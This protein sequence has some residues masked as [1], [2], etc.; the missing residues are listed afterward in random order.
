MF[1]IL[2]PAELH[3]NATLDFWPLCIDVLAPTNN[4]EMENIQGYAGGGGAAQRQF[5]QD[6]KAVFAKMMRD[7]NQHLLVGLCQLEFLKLVGS[8]LTGEARQVLTT[9]LEHCDFEDLRSPILVDAVDIER[10]RQLWREHRRDTSAWSLNRGT[11]GPARPVEPVEHEPSGFSR[12]FDALEARLKISTNENLAQVQS[13][14]IKLGETPDRMF[15]RFYQLVKPLED[16]RPQMMTTE[17]LKTM[18]VFHLHS[19]LNKEDYELL[20]ADCQV[21]EHKRENRGRVPLS[22]SL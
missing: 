1:F 9:F 21:K 18:F 16:E 11:G 8:R 2:A 15:C 12:F 17:Q 13:F 5:L 14:K 20:T 4:R 6:M 3:L 19:L 10:R 22:L 7:P